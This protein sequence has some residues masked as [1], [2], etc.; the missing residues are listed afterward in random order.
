MRASHIRDFIK[1]QSV[2]LALVRWA[3]SSKTLAS[4][5]ILFGQPKSHDAVLR[6]P[7]VFE[8]RKSL[9]FV[10]A[11]KIHQDSKTK[12]LRL[13][14]RTALTGTVVC[15]RFCNDPVLLTCDELGWSNIFWHIYRRSLLSKMSWHHPFTPFIPCT[16][17]MVLVVGGRGYAAVSTRGGTTITSWF[18]QRVVYWWISHLSTRA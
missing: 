3:Y 9:S 13:G 1:R 15:R 8:Q 17:K 5:V 7:Y 4:P 16:A 18:V 12:L 6:K 10:A 11:G 14:P 2:K